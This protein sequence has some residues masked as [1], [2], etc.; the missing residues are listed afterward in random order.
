MGGVYSSLLDSC[1]ITYLPALRNRRITMT[2]GGTQRLGLV[3]LNPFADRQATGS[4]TP[5][6]AILSF[7]LS[8]PGASKLIFS[9]GRGGDF[10]QF[11]IFLPNAR[12]HVGTTLIEPSAYYLHIHVV[13]W[14]ISSVP[15]KECGSLPVNTQAVVALRT[16][17]ICKSTTSTLSGRSQRRAKFVVRHR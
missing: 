12:M 16:D 1:A 4:F 13:T 11:L 10:C 17:F 7:S 14:Q 8:H 2:M 5:P 3:T 15:V 6:Y 9:G